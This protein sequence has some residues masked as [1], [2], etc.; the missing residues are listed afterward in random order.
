VGE[1][2]L[3]GVRGDDA[4]DR[5]R[6]AGRLKDD[7]V[8]GVEATGEELEFFRGG[9]DPP[10][11]PCPAALGDRDPTEVACGTPARGASSGTRSASSSA[12][13]KRSTARNERSGFR[14]SIRV[15]AASTTSRALLSPERT[16]AAVAIASA[17]SGGGTD[18]ALLSCES[19][20]VI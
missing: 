8:R 1:D 13:S 12:A 5:Q 3:G 10:G 17:A 18:A 19:R 14:A 6:I 20:G 16:R 4:G 11:E 2:D 7:P 15:I 9:R